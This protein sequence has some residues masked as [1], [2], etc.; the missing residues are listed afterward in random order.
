MIGR[1]SR[2]QEEFFISGTLEQLIPED[3]ILR[4][5]D[6]VLDLSWIQGIVAE[7]YSA[8]MGRPSIDPECALR[9]M[10]AGFFQNITH[11]RRLMREAQVNIAIRWFAGF[12][13]QDVLPDHS[14]LTRIRQRWGA[15]R[16]E[17]IFKRVVRLCAEAGLIDG[18]TVHI[19]A[20]L[21]RANVAWESVVKTHVEKVVEDNG[22]EEPRGKS[23]GADQPRD[24][25]GT[26]DTGQAQSEPIPER[27]ERKN[28]AKPKVKGVCKT[29]P[30]ATLSTSSVTRR[31]EPCYKHHTAVDDKV[32]VLVDV[33][34][35]TGE[36]SESLELI[37][38]I[39]RIE[40]NTGSTI[41]TVTADAGYGKSANFGELERQGKNAVIVPQPE[42][43]S[44]KKIPVR[45]FKYDA[46]HKRVKCPQGQILHPS[47][48]T[49]R[50]TIYRA[51]AKD[52][53][54]CPLRARCLPKTARA[55]TIAIVKDYEAMLRAR[56]RKLCWDEPTRQ[57]YRRHQNL[58]EGWHGEA[59]TQHG[60][61]RAVR[62]GIENM[63][64]Q[65]YLIGIVMNCKRMV[66][67]GVA[68]TGPRAL[69]AAIL[70]HI[71][72]RFAIWRLKFEIQR[73]EQGNPKF[74]TI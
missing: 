48:Q 3:H 34:I 45:R 59:K 46:R 73:W 30:E 11:D 58:V 21:V 24:A 1:R 55:R 4:R 18:H 57:H 41:T 29:D 10:L 62:R 36:A 17:K 5:V 60:L 32:G 12:T 31:M 63:R 40:A 69:C 9:L 72:G 43:K 15:E 39:A 25:N 8:R 65:A 49:K 66:G 6:A 33:A 16:F 51:S 38:Q 23:D 2:A 22:Q 56:R 50:G 67:Y 70:S 52:C 68:K 42:A 37:D 54:A 7:T 19:D 35:T 61:A 13:L 53:Q 20:T 47:S 28:K 64:I 26:Q 74:A 71:S 14:S 44:A 27:K